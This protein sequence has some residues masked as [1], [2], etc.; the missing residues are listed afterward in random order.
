ME[1]SGPV[2]EKLDTEPAKHH[3]EPAKQ[4]AEQALT[5]AEP[6]K[7]IAEA[8]EGHAEPAMPVAGHWVASAPA[9]GATFR[10]QRCPSFPPLPA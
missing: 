7:P 4:H 1:K 10:N 5:V 3:A 6:A 2:L 9:A 8:A